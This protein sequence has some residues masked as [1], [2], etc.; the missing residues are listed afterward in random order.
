MTTNVTHINPMLAQLKEHH[1]NQIELLKEKIK[2]LEY[3]IQL[4]ENF[5]NRMDDC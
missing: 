3:Q 4:L 2:E 1:R 5:S